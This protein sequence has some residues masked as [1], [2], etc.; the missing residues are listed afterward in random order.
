MKAP[1]SSPHRRQPLT[2]TQRHERLLLIIGCVILFC[3]AL[4][5]AIVIVY[6]ILGK[7]WPPNEPARVLSA[8][9]AIRDG[10]ATEFQLYDPNASPPTLPAQ[11]P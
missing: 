1:H 7:P 4:H 11:R 9:E 10:W 6:G 2:R 3:F 8:E 5:Y